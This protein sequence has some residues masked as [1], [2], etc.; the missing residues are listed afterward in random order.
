[1]SGIQMVGANLVREMVDDV[2]REAASRDHLGTYTIKFEVANRS[3]TEVRKS[4]EERRKPRHPP[5]GT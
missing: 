1:M 2:L 3:V 4:S 5:K